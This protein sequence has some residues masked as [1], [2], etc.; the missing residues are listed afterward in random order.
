MYPQRK[1][2]LQIIRTREQEYLDCSRPLLG[3]TSLGLVCTLFQF[4][5]KAAQLTELSHLLDL[6]IVSQSPS[7]F[8]SV[9]SY[10]F[11]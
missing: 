10:H 4:F 3:E 7:W 5:L 8:S 11:H 6:R 1:E 9:I 2:H